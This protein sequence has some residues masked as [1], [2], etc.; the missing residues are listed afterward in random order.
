M[1]WLMKKGDQWDGGPLRLGTNEMGDQWVPIVYWGT[2]EL[3]DLWVE[4]PMRRGPMRWWTNERGG[5]VSGSQQTGTHIMTTVRERGAHSPFWRVRSSPI[6]NRT[7]RVTLKCSYQWF[8]DCCDIVV[9]VLWKIS[10]FCGALKIPW[11]IAVERTHAFWST[12]EERTRYGARSALDIFGSTQQF[13]KSYRK[14]L[15]F[16]KG[17]DYSS[18]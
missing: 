5:P 4:G 13:F 9:V 15:A 3:E 17:M 11:K 10:V 12:H 14:F 16:Q 1:G 8:I 6:E 2:S 18:F 7:K